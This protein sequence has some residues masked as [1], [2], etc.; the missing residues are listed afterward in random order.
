MS[1]A[2]GVLD[3]V[4]VRNLFFK[5]NV[6]LFLLLLLAMFRAPLKSS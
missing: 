6:L 3:G 4:T 5:K 1:E 2:I